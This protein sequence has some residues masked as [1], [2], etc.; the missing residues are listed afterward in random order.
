MVAHAENFQ[1]GKGLDVQVR[2]AHIHQTYS[3][4]FIQIAAQPCSGR[5]GNDL[6]IIESDIMFA[7]PGAKIR[8]ILRK[9]L[10]SVFL[11]NSSLSKNFCFDQKIPGLWGFQSSIC[12][13][14]CQN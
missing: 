9:V 3:Q 7:A 12:F 6:T 10:I 5:N 8:R 2:T 1:G 4:T 13:E 11:K 14:I